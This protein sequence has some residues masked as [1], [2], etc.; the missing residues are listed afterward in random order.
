MLPTDQPAISRPTE[1]APPASESATGLLRLG[2]VERKVDRIGV[3]RSAPGRWLRPRARQAPRSS[4]PTRRAGGAGGRHPPHS[5][6]RP[7]APARSAPPDPGAVGGQRTPVARS[8]TP[9]ARTAKEGRNDD[10]AC[11]RSSYSPRAWPRWSGS[12]RSTGCFRSPTPRST[13]RRLRWCWRRTGRRCGSSC[14]PTSGGGCRCRSPRWVPTCRGPWW[15]RRTAGSAAIRGSTCWRWRGLPGRTSSR[16]GW[17][18]APPPYRC[19]WRGW[20]IRRRAPSRSSCARPSAPS[21]S[22]GTCAATSCWPTTSTSPPTAATS[23]GS[24]PPPGST[25]ARSRGSSR[26]GRSPCSSPCR[27]RPAA[28]IRR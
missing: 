7:P 3:R 11:S 20:P 1:R 25:S 13:G 16:G 18:R 4:P 2:N 5:D 6:Q 17:C 27:A 8:P 19:S 22:P 23:R 9:P 28:S 26:R 24:A 15:R 21:S 14:P 10:A 12:W